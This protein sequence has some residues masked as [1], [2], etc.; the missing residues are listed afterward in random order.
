MIAAALALAV[1][2]AGCKD[3]APGKSKE[4]MLAA[5]A[6]QS[7]IKAYS[8]AGNA[9]LNIDLPSSK[10]GSLITST[11]TGMIAKG[12]LEWKGAATYEP[13]RMEAELKS[14]PQGASTPME[15]PVILKDNKLYLRLPLLGKQ[16]YFSI[17][18]SELSS[19]SGQSNP[20]AADSMQRIS[21]ALSDSVSAAIADAGAKWFK[22]EK[23]TTLPDG[24]ALTVHRLDI[25][26]KNRA[27]LETAI[28]GKIPEIASHLGSAGLLNTEQQSAFAKASSSFVLE[29][30]GVVS[31]AVDPSGYIREQSL[32]LVYKNTGDDG[33]TA[34]GSISFNQTFQDIN[35]SPVFS[36]EIPVNAKPLGDILKLLA[37]PAAKKTP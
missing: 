15:L 31:I 29:A 7:E 24:G 4:L 8:F 20:F 12:K 27:E 36:Q 37:P 30:P 21:R 25:T 32:S 26:D 33:K 1:G 17:D 3:E 28:K 35:G 19:L 13:V 6:K 9:D 11:L 18:M 2:T 34:N 23:G 16:D 22:E 14:T 10:G 5:L